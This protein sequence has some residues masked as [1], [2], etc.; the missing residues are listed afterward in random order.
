MTSTR[1]LMRAAIVGL[2]ASLALVY[3]SSAISAVNPKLTVTSNNQLGTNVAISAV[4]LNPADDAIGKLQIFVPTGFTFKAPTATVGTAVVTAIWTDRDPGTS[5]L[6]T[7]GIGAIS[8]SAASLAPAQATCDTGSHLAAWMVQVRG[9]D[10]AYSFPVFVDQ[11]AGTETQYGAY[12]LVA[13][14]LSPAAGIPGRA[15]EGNKM[16]SMAL[17]VSGFTLPAKAGNYVWR[18]LWTPYAPNTATLNT[19]G[20]VEAQSTQS[21][22]ASGILNLTGKIVSKARV[23]GQLRTRLALRGTLLVGGEA[24]ANINVAIHHGATKTK[25]V[26]LGSARTN[27]AGVFTKTVTIVGKGAYFQAGA[28]IPSTTAGC[29][30]SFAVPCLSAT[31]GST[32]LISRLIHFEA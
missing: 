18:S 5:I 13:C 28:T 10:D 23:N 15:A 9:S 8:P 17:K 27:A 12:K 6:M 19:V 25:L 32:S 31:A 20:N 1:K 2:A 14:F 30:P 4:D 11:T 3:A 16:V 26:T 21:I 29:T 7:G 22:S 24:A